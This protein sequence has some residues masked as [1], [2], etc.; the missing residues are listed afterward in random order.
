MGTVPNLLN[1]PAARASLEARANMGF[2]LQIPTPMALLEKTSL[3][4]WPDDFQ[5]LLILAGSG[6]S[7][8]VREG[9]LQE[10]LG[11]RYVPEAVDL[12]RTTL[13]ESYDW[14][15]ANQEE[16]R[17]VGLMGKAAGDQGYFINALI[18]ALYDQCSRLPPFA[19]AG[20]NGVSLGQMII[21]A[22]KY[23]NEG[24]ERDGLNEG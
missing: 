12:I 19:L 1:S 18:Y 4:T 6:E 22:Q 21:V 20:L 7:E 3:A 8:A 24:K 11:N 5:Y 2:H 13:V 16:L 17:E 23:I 14:A 15:M 9:H 10:Y